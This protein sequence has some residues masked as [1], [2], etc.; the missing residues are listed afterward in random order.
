M[1]FIQ[2]WLA[3]SSHK[4]LVKSFVFS[5]FSAFFL[6]ITSG[7]EAQLTVPQGYTVEV[8]VEAISMPAA[9]AFDSNGVMYVG[10]DEINPGRIYKVSLGG[11]TVTAFGPSLYDPDAIAVDAEDHVL[12]GSESQGLYRV[13]PDGTSS[14]LTILYMGNTVAI[15]VDRTGMFDAV[16]TIFV[17]N[18]RSSYDIVK[19]LPDGTSLP[20]VTNNPDLYISF[21]LAIGEGTLYVAEADGEGQGRKGIYEVPA[22]NTVQDFSAL[23]N[24]F[25][26]AYNTVQGK[27]YVSQ[28]DKI[29]SISPE[30]VST[31]FAENITA[32]GMTFGPDGALYVSSTAE[33]RIYRISGAGFLPNPV[34]VAAIALGQDQ[35]LVVDG[36]GSYSAS[37]TIVSYDWVLTNEDPQGED[38]LLTGETV[39]LESVAVGCYL[40]T[41]TVT[42]TSGREGIDRTEVCV[43]ACM[44]QIIDDD[45]DG[46]STDASDCNDL[47]ASINPGAIELCDGL[48]NN[49]D[50]S[51]DEGFDIDGDLFTECTGDCNDADAY[52]N[53]EAIELPGNDIDENCDGS[54]GDCDPQ[55]DWKNHGEFVRCVAHEVDGLVTAGIISEAEGDLLVSSAARSDV[56]KN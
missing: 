42:D 26:L 35:Q 40:A 19:V 25:C 23:T 47:D 11:T 8:Y 17:A 20:F 49:C 51:I 10:H 1:A 9:L 39:S 12:V 48:D 24:P 56:G 33:S 45:N 22:P 7:A 55:A 2:Q 28:S 41:L 31:L 43:P 44:P 50:G 5:L 52:V 3:S 37:D 16:G 6:A 34:A 29:Y 38:F 53:P 30:G 54:L 13:S 4:F 27:L 18:A 36:S 32:R 46:Y 14:V 15:A 21:G